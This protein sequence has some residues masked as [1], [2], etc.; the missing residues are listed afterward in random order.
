L[1]QREL[2]VVGAQGIIIVIIIAILDA[3][4]EKRLVKAATNMGDDPMKPFRVVTFLAVVLSVPLLGRPQ[5]N[6]AARP[7][8]RL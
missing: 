6:P 2:R 4:M 5:R 7:K 8:T 1:R 3:A